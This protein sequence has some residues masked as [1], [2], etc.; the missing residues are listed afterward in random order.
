M[1]AYREE[2]RKVKR[3]IYQSNN[4][5]NEKFGEKMNEDVNGNM[6]LFWKEVSNVKG[7]KVE[8]YS[9]IKDL[10]G[11]LAQGEDEVRMIWK[12]YFE[13]LYNIDTQEHV[14]VYMCAFD[15]I[16]RGNYFGEEPTGRAD[17]EVIKRETHEWK[18]HRRGRDNWSNDKR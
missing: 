13:D 9:R 16:R 10:S 18:G 5:V 4:K 11:R 17:V 3:F 7:G 12:A 15:G 8:S 6:K 1:E 2:K 14:A